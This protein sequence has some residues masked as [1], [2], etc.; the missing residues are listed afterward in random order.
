MGSAEM[1]LLDTHVWLWFI[2]NPDM[3]SKKAKSEVTTAKKTKSLLISSISAW[4]IA[5]LVNKNRL[6]LTMDTL[7]WI[8]TSQQLPFFRFIPID[9]EIAVHSVNLPDPIHNDPADRIIIATAILKKAELVTKDHKIRN[10]PHV[11]T[12]W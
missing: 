4:E 8:E 6:E 11:K 9:N 7:D 1:I 2:S 10:Y 5:M 12:I 3:L